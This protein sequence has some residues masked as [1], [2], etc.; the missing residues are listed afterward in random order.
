[1]RKH[2]LLSL[3][4]IA[5]LQ[6]CSTTKKAETAPIAVVAPSTPTPEPVNY[7]PSRTRI[8]D[9][10]HTKLEVS[11]DYPKQYL[12]GKATITVKPYF[13]P[14]FYLDL[15]AQG[16]DIKT[17]SLVT[18][19][20]KSPLK[21]IYDNKVLTITLDRIYKNT[22]EYKVYIEY[23]AKPNDLKVQGSAA[24]NDA[25][26]LYFINPLGTEKNKPTQIWTQGEMQSNSCWF[27]TIDSP[28]E[29]MTQEIYMTVP[30][31][32]VTLSNGLLLLSRKNTDGTRTDYW[33]QSLAAAP[34]LTMMAVGDFAIVKDKWRGM[35]VNYYV[36]KD[37]EKYAKQAFGATPDMLEF[38]S[39]RLGVYYPWEK[40]SQI[41]VRDYVSG[42]M[43][44]TG[45]VLHG[46]ALMK[47]DREM[48]DDSKE[49]YVAHE[50]FH[51]WFGDLVT[52]ESWSNLPLNESFATYGEYLWNEHKNGI[53][54]ADRGLQS[55]LN[56]YLQQSRVKDPN[57]I[58]FTYNDKEDMFDGISYQK[59]GCVLHMLRKYVG[60]DA[61]FASLKLYLINNKFKAVEIHNLRLAFEE[62]TGEDLNW[63]FNQWFLDHGHPD[64][65]IK[66]SY[67]DTTKKV[68]ITIEQVQDF[69]K[70]PLFKLPIKIDLYSGKK[71]ESHTVV[72]NK[73][74]EVF[75]FDA[76]VNPDL[77]NVDAEKMLLCTKTD[78][79]SVYEL[80]FQYNNA[81]L[82]MD[83]YEAI[84]QLGALPDSSELVV[85]TLVQGLS[86]P[87]WSIRLLS[88]K[89][90][91][92]ALSYNSSAIKTQ[93]ITMAKN[94]TKSYVRAAA[95]KCLATNF[96]SPE[97]TT[98]YTNAIGEDKS[99]AVLD[100]ALNGLGEKHTDK[101]LEIAKSFE[102][103]KS[104]GVQ[105]AL[106]NLYTE[107]GTDEQNAYFISALKNSTGVESYIIMS[108]YGKFLLKCSDKT[109]YQSLAPIE[110]MGKN[111]S[112]WYARFAAVQTLSGLSKKY[113]DVLEEENKKLTG[114]KSQKKPDDNDLKM[115]ES[116]VSDVKK[117]K[118]YIDS[119]IDGIKKVE[120]DPTLMKIYGTATE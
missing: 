63:F 104:K 113:E 46:E 60:D 119:L 77:V 67:N 78:K 112:I 69:S 105:K 42:A 114:I 15:D 76:A 98:L 68:V 43:E 10:I 18:G 72:I 85:K 62:V 97:L 38:F 56:T 70:N 73:A 45:A 7:Q 24:I 25:K 118:E 4:A 92:K 35:E 16:M 61:F 27:P 6:G 14:A 21:Y 34:Y 101:A 110:D 8:N 52:C 5:A 102:L 90:I 53:D 44:N 30:D 93:L 54:E 26:G 39:T 1:M 17:V 87:F 36:E 89:N 86:D 115:A 74:K 29:R 120:K 20:I 91:H 96:D 9:I 71:V 116:A 48:I 12:Y 49:E 31:K 23:T 66:H 32:Y 51:Q 82:Y 33:K 57:L 2:L 65:D 94:D 83:R 81:P 99:Y 88:I 107:K 28:N 64:L 59:G 41:V 13:K 84:Q 103:D 117:K 100:V 58:R 111:G 37:Y 79:K 47:T 106:V 50:L 19:D 95:I 80:A 109:I 75:T 11:F 22:E 40:F 108:S 3:A 55:D